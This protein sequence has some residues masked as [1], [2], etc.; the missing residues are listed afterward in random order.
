MFFVRG[1][2]HFVGTVHMKSVMVEDNSV[3]VELLLAAISCIMV[4]IDRVG[5]IIQWNT[6]AE[7]IFGTPAD[8]VIGKSLRQCGVKWDWA[9][10]M[11]QIDRCRKENVQTSIDDIKFTC[12][13]ESDGFLGL[14]ANPIVGPDRK[15]SGVLLLGAD[16]TEQKLL[17]NQLAQAQKLEAMGQL[18]AGIAHEINTPTQ[19]VG[20]NTRFLQDSYAELFPIITKC[21][22][23]LAEMSGDEGISPEAI[24]E[25][26]EAFSRADVEYLLD[27]IPRAISQSLEGVGRVTKIVHAMKEF[28]HPNTNSMEAVNLN[29]AI[30]STVTV[31][32]NEWKYVADLETDF[33]GSLPPVRCLAGDFSQVILNLTINAAHAIEDNRDDQRDKKGTITISTRQDDQWVEIRIS[34][35]GCGIPPEAREKIFNLFFTT[36]E[37]GRGTGQ[38]LAIARAVVVE[39]HG[40]TIDFESQVGKGTT[41][42]IRIPIDGQIEEMNRDDKKIVEAGLC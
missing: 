37:I 17:E 10:V 1:A 25:L 7:K 12:S 22:S 13:D 9:E 39:K 16:I 3:T 34:D 5:N 40:G 36:K 18:A 29:G 31:C 42:V 24:S 41:F 20:D 30:E 4:S 23:L 27:E 2:G 35:T 19:Y 14:T 28:S 8:S 6:A 21:N 26:K 32:R 11:R 38:G 15:V 33:D